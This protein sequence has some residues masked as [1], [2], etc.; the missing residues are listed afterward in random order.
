MTTL[1][2]TALEYEIAHLAIRE[3]KIRAGLITPRL[4]DEQ[5]CAWSRE[6]TV[7]ADKLD[8]IHNWRTRVSP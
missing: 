4:D 3:T 2:D 5:E 7:T 8:T 6:G 1:L